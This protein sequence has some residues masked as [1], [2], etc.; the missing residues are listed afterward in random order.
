MGEGV[1]NDRRGF[2]DPWDTT[3]ARASMVP[4][5]VE[6]NPLSAPSSRPPLPFLEVVIQGK[7]YQ[8]L[9]W[10]VTGR[11]VLPDS[12]LASTA[13]QQMALAEGLTAAEAAATAM[14]CSFPVPRACIALATRI[15][16]RFGDN[17]ALQWVKLQL[18]AGGDQGSSPQS[19]D[20]GL[21]VAGEQQSFLQLDDAVE[22]LMRARPNTRYKLIAI[23]T[24]DE[25]PHFV[26]AELEGVIFPA[27]ILP[28]VGAEP[29]A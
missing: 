13:A 16:V 8:G 23:N 26:A 5:R 12:G 22:V 27:S 20:S 18:V 6:Y 10:R 24:D 28:P 25:V 14:V 29:C 3:L 17:T 2:Q 9:P 4:E 15:R 21:V 11:I 19:G 1:N 7:K